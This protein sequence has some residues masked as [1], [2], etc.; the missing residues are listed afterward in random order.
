MG[1]ERCYR[2]PPIK[3]QNYAYDERAPRSKYSRYIHARI[4]RQKRRDYLNFASGMH[5]SSRLVN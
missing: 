2:S 1:G 3:I 5:I 4:A